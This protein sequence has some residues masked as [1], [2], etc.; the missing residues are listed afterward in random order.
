MV[1]YNL[2][3]SKTVSA[4]ILVARHTCDLFDHTKNHF[5]NIHPEAWVDSSAVVI[6]EV[7][8]GQK[9]SVLPTCVLR[10]DQ[11]LDLY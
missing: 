7:E 2:L 10:G 5:P 8:L 1:A 6:G 9:V 3:F 11:G 4:I